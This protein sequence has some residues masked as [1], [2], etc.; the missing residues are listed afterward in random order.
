ML[1]QRIELAHCSLD[2]YIPQCSVAHTHKRQSIVICPGGGYEWLS[3]REAEPVA[4]AFMAQ[5]FNTFVVWYRVAPNT[6]PAALQDV[7]QAVAWVRA[8]ADTF[9]ADPDAIA[10]MGFSAGGHAAGHLGVRWHDAE[11]MA[12]LGLKCEDVRPNAQVLCYPVISGG[13]FAHRGSFENLSGSR[14]AADHPA[15]SLE[16]LVTPNTPP[17]FLWHN[18]D[19]GCVPVMNTLLM[20]QS[21]RAANV[22]TEVHILPGGW[23]GLSLA[24]DATADNA[25][26][27]VPEV[28][29]WVKDAGRFLRRVMHCEPV[30]P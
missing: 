17:T 6:H 27:V 12:S 9:N 19:D 7:A 3:D 15:Y 1:H 25:E 26:M 2:C 29:H 23:H 16:K 4:L 10:V 30:A 28:A 5:S 8:H 21:L 11:L 24:N 14:D 18:W 20:A 22:D 13:A